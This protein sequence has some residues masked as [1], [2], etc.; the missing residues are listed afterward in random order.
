MRADAEDA[1]LKSDAAAA[2]LSALEA[3][4][5]IAAFLVPLETGPTRLWNIGEALREQR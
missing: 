2:A 1:A 4:S 3:D 5:G